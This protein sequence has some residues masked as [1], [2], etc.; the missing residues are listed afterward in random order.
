[1]TNYIQTFNDS[2]GNK[3]ALL[4]KLEHCGTG[5]DFLTKDED[6]MQVAYM[7]HPAGHSII[8][9][10][11]NRIERIIDYTCETLVMRKGVLEVTLYENQEPCYIFQIKAGDILTLFS[12]GHG[13]KVVENVEMVEIKQGPYAGPNDKTRF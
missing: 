4:V 6:Y 12:G 13:F 2:K 11:H 8:P 10:Y 7:G 3:L 1:M 5:I 9:H